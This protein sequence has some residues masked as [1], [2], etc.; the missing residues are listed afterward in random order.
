MLQYPHQ[1]NN[2]LIGLSCSAALLSACASPP[3]PPQASTPAQQGVDAAVPSTVSAKGRVSATSIVPGET[4]PRQFHGGFELQADASGGQLMLLTP[5]GSTVAVL[6]WT[7]K[8]ALL[9]QATGAIAAFD[10]AEQMME[11]AIGVPVQ[12]QALS[13]WL[14]GVPAHG[15]AV[16][17]NSAEQFTQLGWTVN[18]LRE[19]GASHARR[20][21]ISRPQ[22][23]G[24]TAAELRVVIDELQ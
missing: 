2:L 19:A 20:L 14:R 23:P 1:F 8:S 13:A 22:S 7:P 16:E 11:Q 17:R 21:E 9:R 10:S 24:L 6:A 3:H 15:H 5:L 4:Q 12:P 18:V